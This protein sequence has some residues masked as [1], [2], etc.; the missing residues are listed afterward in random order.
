MKTIYVENILHDYKLEGIGYAF[1]SKKKALAFL[2]E[3]KEEQGYNVRGFS[4]EN[5]W[6]VYDSNGTTVQVNFQETNL[7]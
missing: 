1:T 4:A 2:L 5:L 3:L 7:L 6:I